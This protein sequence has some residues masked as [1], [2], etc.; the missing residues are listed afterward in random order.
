MDKDSVL[1]PRE[2]EVW[3]LVQ[4]DRTKRE[5]AETLRMTPN[6]V[7]VFVQRIRA[8]LGDGP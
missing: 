2:R 5:I 7:L 1:T 8:K 6:T 3:K 4:A